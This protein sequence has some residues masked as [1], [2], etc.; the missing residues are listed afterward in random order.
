MTKKDKILT[1]VENLFKKHKLS[2]I[3]TFPEGTTYSMFYTKRDKLMLLQH[4]KIELKAL[5][6]EVEQAALID[7]NDYVIKEKSSPLYVK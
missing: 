3:I 6:I 7:E 2:A 5:D 1:S 4:A